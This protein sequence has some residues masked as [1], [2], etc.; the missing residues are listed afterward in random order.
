MMH[1][2]II[3]QEESLFKQV[4]DGRPMLYQQVKCYLCWSWYWYSQLWV[5]II[6][7]IWYLEWNCRIDVFHSATRM[8]HGSAE[9][10]NMISLFFMSI[11]PILFQILLALEQKVG[12]VASVKTTSTV[13]WESWSGF[14][15][16]LLNIS[17]LIP[18][19]KLASCSFVD[20]TLVW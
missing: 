13:K 11:S 17:T 5:Y 10:C 6:P 4:R 19:M 7:F 20:D 14:S 2:D 16:T 8:Y 15:C 9:F 3:V 12:G 18:P 1:K